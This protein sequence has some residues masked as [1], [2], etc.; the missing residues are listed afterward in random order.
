MNLSD[1]RH[2][3]GLKKGTYMD[4]KKTQNG[5]TTVKELHESSIFLSS[6]KL[7][8]KKKLLMNK[9]LVEDQESVSYIFLQFTNL[10][11]HYT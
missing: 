3:H 1:E 8:V 7:D 11:W 10:I 2:I 4:S 9:K 6:Y 5:C